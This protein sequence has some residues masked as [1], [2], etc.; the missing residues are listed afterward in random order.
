VPRI[1]IKELTLPVLLLGVGG[2]ALLGRRHGGLLYGV[3]IFYALFTYI[4]RFGNWFQVVMPAYPLIVLGLAI[5]AHRL[6]RPS[7]N[8]ARVLVIL[9]LALLVANRLGVNF[10]G[11][12]QRDRP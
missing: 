9:A 7:P 3:L 12:D 2:I 1:I 4:D 10:P 6:F 5:L 8:W 11:A